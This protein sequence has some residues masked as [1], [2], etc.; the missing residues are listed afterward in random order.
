MD[1]KAMNNATGKRLLALIRDA[2]YAHPGEEDA[3][4]LLFAGLAPDR[5]RRILDAGCGGGG[6][7]AWVQEHD[8]GTLTGVE[9]DAETV[10]LGRDRH[11]DVTIVE[12]DLQTAAGVLA[13]PFDLMYAMTALYAV[14]DQPAAFAQLR[15]LAA[16]G[17]ELRLLEYSDPHGSFAAAVRGHP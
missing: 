8:Y 17:A 15:E 14:P 3:N 16:P 13:G 11:P 4:R 9:I 12:G 5:G 1:P 7:A 6:T 2:D 10:L